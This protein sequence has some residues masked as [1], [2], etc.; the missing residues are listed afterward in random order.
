MVPEEHANTGSQSSTLVDS[1]ASTLALPLDPYRDDSISL[2]KESMQYSL[3]VIKKLPMPQS[4]DMPFAP[5]DLSRALHAV[6]V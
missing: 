2:V 3:P 6:P 5:E 1:N 4:K